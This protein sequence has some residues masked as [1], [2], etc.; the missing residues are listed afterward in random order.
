MSTPDPRHWS[1]IPL[2]LLIACASEDSGPAA[3]SAEGCILNSADV[4]DDCLE[5]EHVV[6]IGSVSGPGFI[7]GNAGLD[8]VVRDGF[9][10]F[11]IGDGGYMNVYGPG[12][13]FIRTVGR[14]GEG[15][16]EFQWAYPFHA[17]AVGN[18]HVWDPRNLR[19]TIVSPD[20][21]LV[22]EQ[23]LSAQWEPNDM[24]AL[25]DGDLYVMQTWSGDAANPGQPL[26]IV[27][28]G[29]VLVSFGAEYGPGDDPSDFNELDLRHA[30][31]APDGSIMVAHQDEYR[32]EV[33][34][35][36]GR[37]Q[38]SL[39]GPD[40]ENTPGQ[41]GPITPENPLPNM[42][43]D[44]H[45][46]AAGRAWVS[47]LL[48]RPDWVEN[49]EADPQGGL[50]PIGMDVRNWVRSRIDVIDVGTCTLLASHE[51]DAL[52]MDFMEDGLVAD[53]VY[54]PEGA[55]LIDVKRVRLREEAD[56][57]G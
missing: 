2:A 52:V 39:T 49:S 53:V 24:M 9:G 25:D 16:M 55:P 41:H 40:L 1:A 33:W 45:V 22:D 8:Q 38:A 3:S 27:D 36:D 18:M 57:S 20:L 31:T 43:K 7:S 21:A 51:Q 29:E 50:M 47:L 35:R 14:E 28:G 13:E 34:S 54:S 37:L 30:A 26:H 56:A 15:P 6:R 12:G 32:V 44:M 5:L 4:C 19:V 23:P 48:R 42:I 11:W 46:D 10:N 17:D